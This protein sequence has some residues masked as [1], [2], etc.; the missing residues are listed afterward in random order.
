MELFIFFLWHSK[1]IKIKNNLRIQSYF[2]LLKRWNFELKAL[3]H[4]NS[5]VSKE[6]A[7]AIY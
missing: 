7:E 1:K 5:R 4:L 3:I 2:R 6:F